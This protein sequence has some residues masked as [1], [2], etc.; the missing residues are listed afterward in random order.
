MLLILLFGILRPELAVGRKAIVLKPCVK[1][2][3]GD[4]ASLCGDI[5]WSGEWE[6]AVQVVNG[7]SGSVNRR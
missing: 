5:M 6:S 3:V 7:S 2:P 1:L 4:G